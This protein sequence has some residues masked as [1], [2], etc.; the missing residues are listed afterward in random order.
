M[1]KSSIFYIS[2][3]L[4]CL[5]ALLGACTQDEMS[6]EGEVRLS[7]KT[8]DLVSIS[9]LAQTKADDQTPDYTIRIY[10]G[11]GLIRK[12]VNEMPG[13]LWLQSGSYRVTVEVGTAQDAAF[14]ATPYFK[15]EESF[16]VPSGGTINVT[17]NCHI[18]NTLVSVVFDPAVV[19]N[20]TDYAAEVFTTKGR[21]TFTAENLDDVAYFM[22]PEGE[23]A[24]GWSFT[25]QTKTGAP[26][27]KTGMINDATGG[28]K[29]VLTF[30]FE[31]GEYLNNGGGVLDLKVDETAL[32]KED[33]IVVYLR[34]SI[35]GQDFDIT[36]PLYVEVG[37]GD[38]QVVWVNTSSQL[39]NVPVSA[40]NV[41]AIPAE[42]LDL[43][44][45]SDPQQ[46]SLAAAGITT[47][48]TY[49]ALADQ[50]AMKIEFSETFF[51]NLTEGEYHIDITAQDKQGKSFTQRFSIISSN[52]IVMTVDVDRATIWT[53]KARLKA[54]ILQPTSD[55]LSFQYR[56]SGASDWMVA[57][58]T[59]SENV[60]TADI[61][62]LKPNTT[63][64]YRAVAGTFTSSVVKTFT[65]EEARQ[66]ENASFDRWSTDSSDGADVIYGSGEE[67]FWDSGN[68]GSITMNVN[69]TTKSSDTHSGEGYSAKLQSQ[70]VSFF[71]IGKFAA[72]NLFAGRYVETDVTDGVLDFGRPFTSRPAKLRFWYKYNSGIVD[73]E[74][75]SFDIPENERETDIGKSDIANIYVALG[76]WSEP[77]RIRTKSS[78]RK[79]FDK[80]DPNIIAFGELKQG[81]TVGEWTQYTIELDY[82]SYDRIPTYLVITASAS[83]YGDYFVGSTSSVLYLDDMELI[84]E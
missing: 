60:M 1:K 68:H 4:F 15:G 50:S 47:S 3:V 5:G 79:L 17:V 76:D 65:T 23:S 27:T 66:L 28:M 70:F 72:G 10:S 73:K 19:S 30:G 39:M 25:A 64:Q 26:F 43:M 53:S 48:V 31:E 24:L 81:Q 32:V 63:Y 9:G 34:P 67:M 16:D 41:S 82:R 44:K 56:E 46:E 7:F 62:G 45:L 42:G 14:N 18:A 20:F 78:D 75:N 61:T 52:A 57:N 36:K 51:A 40:I 37:E 71:G 35:T 69:V 8:D 11:D 74:G 83:I 55:E 54:S 2:I 38:R 58:A 13:S 29:Y 59:Q 22:L 77:V 33:N 6:G 84:Y 21:L 49:D 12:Y 80:N